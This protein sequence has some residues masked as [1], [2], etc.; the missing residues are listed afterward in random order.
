MFICLLIVLVRQCHI[1]V[2][3]LV[4]DCNLHVDVNALF[5]RSRFMCFSLM[6]VG[7]FRDH[8]KVLAVCYFRMVEEPDGHKPLSNYRN[9]KIFHVRTR[10]V[11]ILQI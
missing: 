7:F 3:Y 11:C 8:D 1:I 9:V 10:L 4:N 6:Y 2:G 5:S